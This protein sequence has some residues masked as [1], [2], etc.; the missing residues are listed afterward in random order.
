MTEKS[1][2]GS[3][4]MTI[5]NGIMLLAMGVLVLITPWATAIPPH[6]LALDYIAGGIMAVGGLASIVFGFVTGRS[7]KKS[8]WYSSPN[9][10]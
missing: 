3:R 9:E 10:K 8:E 4:R 2:S 1:R 7:D 6:Q 5:P